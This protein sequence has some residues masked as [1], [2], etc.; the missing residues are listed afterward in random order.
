MRMQIHPESKFIKVP[1]LK[2]V[3]NLL[4]LQTE[5][6]F[7]PY[8]LYQN[9]RL[10]RTQRLLKKYPKTLRKVYL[11][12]VQEGI[13]LTRS[14]IEAK[15]GQ[16]T[17]DLS[18]SYCSFVGRVVAS[19][20][21]RTFCEGDRVVAYGFAQP[22]YADH[23]LL[24]PENCMQLA[25]PSALS[26]G[27]LYGCLIAH[28]IEEG[29]KKKK[30]KHVGLVGLKSLKP[31]A[32]LVS[33]EKQVTFSFFASLKDVS[34]SDEMLLIVPD[35]L[36]PQKHDQ[37]LTHADN[38]VVLNPKH[39]ST[40]EA[41]PFQI[42]QFPDPVRYNLDIYSQTS[43][44][45]PVWLS[46]QMREAFLRRVISTTSQEKSSF[47][48]FGLDS[49]LTLDALQQTLWLPSTGTETEKLGLS[50]AGAGNFSRAYL[51][52][53]TLKDKDVELRGVLDRR[54]EIGRQ[55]GQ[56]MG[57]KFVTTDYQAFLD[58]PKTHGIFIATYHDSHAELAIE[59]LESDK[60]VFV[61]KPP[62]VDWDQL[63]RLKAAVN[64]E[65]FL[66]VGY[67]RPYAP[68]M[69]IAMQELAQEQGPT[70]VTCI[71]RIYPIPPTHWYYWPNQ[72]SRIV[73]NS[74]HWIDLGYRLVGKQKPVAVRSSHAVSG[75]PD[76]DHAII[77]TFEDGSMVNILF[78]SRGSSIVT[79]Q[80]FIDIKRGGL[81]L[82][83]DDFQKLILDKG[84]KRKNGALS[85]R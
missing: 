16:D 85:K 13:D 40:L 38:V 42:F 48:V 51:M 25:D 60:M 39:L 4:L 8:D 57:A 29:L 52:H 77:I 71:L 56:D 10:E 79:G 22:A 35:H 74:C 19:D 41:S 66:F 43:L 36:N 1:D 67:N 54:S 62:V 3:D 12:A 21:R 49:K 6:A 72:G 64:S 82:Q 30:I 14:K 7:V 78:S 55:V 28:L 84:G 33:I 63:E 45:E 65:R 70:T 31:F 76:E 17:C 11:Y 34:M 68:L 59:A 50:F 24:P 27:L 32:E 73:S 18:A 61:E 83:L 44:Y 75:R 58:D 26:A 5:E 2:P 15:F 53:Y 80:E 23:Y 20:A 46:T 37:L 9:N 81:S 47:W 69:E